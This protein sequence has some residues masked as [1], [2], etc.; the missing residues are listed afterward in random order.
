MHQHIKDV[1]AA[2]NQKA[3]RHKAHKGEV[4]F[5]QIEHHFQQVA[6]LR[7][8]EYIHM[9]KDRITAPKPADHAGGMVRQHLALHNFTHNRFPKAK[10]LSQ[11]G[12]PQSVYLSFKGT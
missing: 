2:V 11:R 8:A 1:A 5:A 3:E 12:S 10:G 6:R 4:A 7:V 9:V